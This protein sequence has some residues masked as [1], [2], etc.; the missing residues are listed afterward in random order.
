[1][2]FLKGTDHAKQSHFIG[3]VFSVSHM[4]RG[5]TPGYFERIPINSRSPEAR[6]LM[7]SEDTACRIVKGWKYGVDVG[8]AR[9]VGG[10]DDMHVG[11]CDK[12]NS[13]VA[14]TTTVCGF[15]IHCNHC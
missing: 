7:F 12:A 13:H 6:G 5:C 1:M 9:M 4:K 14:T 15:L 8:K 3:G 10:E 11:A 2:Q